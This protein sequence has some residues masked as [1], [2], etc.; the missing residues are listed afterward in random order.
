M[1]QTFLV[2]SV[3][4]LFTAFASRPAEG[5]VSALERKA[6]T[7]LFNATSGNGWTVRTGWKTPPLHT[8]GFALPGTEGSWHGVTVTLDQVTKVS[9]WDNN[10]VGHIPAEIGNLAHLRELQLGDNQLSGALPPEIGNLAQLTELRLSVNQLSGPIP[11][12][13]WGLA[14]LTEMAIQSNQ[15]TGGLSSAVGNLTSLQL[16]SLSYNQLSG[17]I[18][19]AI[20][21][22]VSLEQLYLDQNQ[23]SGPIPASLFALPHL[24]RLYIYRNALTGGIPPQAWNQPSLRVLSLSDNQLTGTLPAEVGNAVGLSVLKLSGNQFTGSLPAELGSMTNLFDLGLSNNLFSG[25][26]PPSLGLLGSLWTL[27]LSG[28]QLTGGIPSSLGN[29]AGL[30]HLYLSN[31]RLSG[32]IPATLGNIPNL[33]S[34]AL[35]GNQLAGTVP[36]SLG[37]LTH[38]QTLYLHNNAL[39]GPLPTGLTALTPLIWCRLGYNMF[40]TSDPALRAFLALKDPDWEETQTVPPTGL[41][42]QSLSPV[43]ARLSWT[44]IL[45]TADA[46]AYHVYGR[47]NPGGVLALLG[48]TADKAADHLDLAG[49]TPSTTYYLRIQTRTE[50][51]G[52]QQN[53]LMSPQSVEVTVSTPDCF[54]PGI[55]QPPLSRFILAGQGVTLSVSTSGTAP[56]SYQWY[57]G[58]TGDTT[59]PVGG[60]SNTYATGPLAETTRFWVRVTNVCGRADSAA[61]DVT[62][63]D[64]SFDVNDDGFLDGLDAQALAQRLAGNLQVLPCGSNCP[65]L[66]HDGRVDI[67][68]LHLLERAIESL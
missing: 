11:E 2:L 60:D 54:A 3:A 44:P 42:T 51:H 56:R 39:S 37:N 33:F 22:L 19:A 63:Y 1:K 16:L 57:R 25:T 13:V 50:A 62:V 52:E 10:L 43:S 45:Y 49:L 29:L 36:G 20:G 24:E 48:S 18:P 64:A 68:D 26:I 7:A 21:N 28:N 4:A 67:L 32:A 40:Y 30:N 59:H 34:L 27:D 46:G 66:N 53:V 8:D 9:L 47:T 35:D 61:A 38:L 5:A 55:T 15:F 41:A 6:L 17:S 23:F 12:T 65:D 31:N 14:N 58:N